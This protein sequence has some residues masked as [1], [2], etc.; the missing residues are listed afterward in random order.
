MELWLLL[1]AL[2][3]FVQ[4]QYEVP[5]ATVEVYSPRGLKVSIPGNKYNIYICPFFK[6]NFFPEIVMSLFQFAI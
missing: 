5:Q 3:R 4:G 6:F 2:I 1:F